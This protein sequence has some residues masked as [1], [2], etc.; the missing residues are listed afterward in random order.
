MSA[1]KLFR[2]NNKIFSFV[3]IKLKVNLRSK[4]V[5]RLD[6]FLESVNCRVE[7]GKRALLSNLE[8]IHIVKN[9]SLGL[10]S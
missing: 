9:R 6:R 10:S 4:A 1:G 5:N 2:G 7:I 3:R 8:I